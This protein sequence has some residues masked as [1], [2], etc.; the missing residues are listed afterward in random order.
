MTRFL[1][2]PI[3]AG[4]VAAAIA[5][6]AIYAA[7]LYAMPASLLVFDGSEAILIV[8][9]AGVITLAVS[10]YVMMLRFGL[11]LMR[12]TEGLAAFEADMRRRIARLEADQAQ[13]VETRLAING[14][15]RGN[16]L[17]VKRTFT[18]PADDL[19]DFPPEMP[20]SSNSDVTN[21]VIQFDPGARGR[22]SHLAQAISAGTGLT[23]TPEEGT[24]E[25]WFQPVIS[26]PGRKTRYFEAIAY[27]T[28]GETKPTNRSDSGYGNGHAIEP[29]R[30]GTAE[31]DQRML[32]QSLKLLREL[33]RTGKHAGVIWRLH[34]TT[35]K[36]SR[37]F[38]GLE[39]ILD[40]NGALA[41]RL[42][43]RID[44]RDYASLD[45]IQI[46]RLHRL[47]EMGFA[48]AIADCLDTAAAREAMQSGLFSIVIVDVGRIIAN[49]G[50]ERP[51]HRL[52]ASEQG[53]R[54]VEIIARGVSDEQQA[55]ALID[56]DVLLAQGD[57]FS[58]PRP[59]R[60]TDGSA[61]SG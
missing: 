12:R 48:L 49:G 6:F 35:L 27:Q 10:S 5:A 21:K 55:V 8:I 44:Y 22:T 56:H 24:I 11:A 13:G 19:Q 41:D 59:M 42:V 46:G 14:T 16:G 29:A 58:E 43:A 60:R 61:G 17:A 4:L 2:L 47:C 51:I 39:R 31:I 57:F 30:A 52:I 23:Q 32:E 33:S 15:D 1:I 53:R 3:L 36:D 37:A 34:E 45:V 38:A 54:K 50:D 26:L 25:A 7:T 18:A 28:D 40:A 9:S 20:G